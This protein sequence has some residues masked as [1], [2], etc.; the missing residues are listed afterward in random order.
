METKRCFFCDKTV[1]TVITG[2]FIRFTGCCCAPDG[3]YRLRQDS[4]VPFAALPY[5]TKRQAFPLISAYIRDLSERGEQVA[6]SFDDMDAIRQSPRIPVSI[7]DKAALLLNYLYRKAGGPNEPVVIRHLAD[8]CNLTY[9][10]SLQ[11]LVYIIEKLRDEQLIDR[12]GTV[13][14]LTETGWREASS[15]AEGKP[16]K[17]CSVFVPNRDGMRAEWSEKLF[18]IVERCGYRPQIA[19]MAQPDCDND[20]TFRLIAESKLLIADITGHEPEAYFAAGLALGSDVP[21]LWTV[22]RTDADRLP[23]RSAHIRPFVWDRVEELADMLQ[24]RF[25]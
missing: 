14:K 11:E 7:E 23:V 1:P 16:L 5:Q 12:A 19:D 8:N 10:P 4:C 18:P 25:G 20:D 17:P 21:V 9:S 3:S 6:L 2:N 24:Q 13:F 15:R 22:N